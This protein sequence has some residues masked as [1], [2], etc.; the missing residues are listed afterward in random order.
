MEG[1][2][3]SFSA[4]ILGDAMFQLLC[5]EAANLKSPA[6]FPRQALDLRRPAGDC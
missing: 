3:Y 5:Q 1:R 6:E 4:G 2:V